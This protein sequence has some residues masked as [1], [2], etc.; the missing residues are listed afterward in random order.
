MENIVK[1]KKKTP[2]TIIHSMSEERIKELSPLQQKLKYEFHNISFL[3]NALTHKSFANE[4]KDKKLYIEDNERLEFLG[5][6]I[7]GYI[8]TD[9]LMEKFPNYSEGMLSKLRAHVVSE[10]ILAPIASNNDLGNYILLGKGEEN[11]GGRL[12]KSILANCFE[13]LIAGIYLD[14][15]L[16][17]VRKFVIQN[18]KPFIEEANKKDFIP[19]FKTLVQEYSQGKLNCTPIYRV[20]GQNGLDHEKIFEVKLIINNK[21][22]GFGEGRSK[23]DAEQ[24]A[25]YEALKNLKFK[26][27]TL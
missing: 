1:K 4:S 8:I 2:A 10:N 19:D 24:K 27:L 23:K 9:F 13:A 6:A 22:F 3:N 26:G 17:A 5:D 14:R 11:S 18:V 21:T 15:G 20:T 25:A 7:L 16:E 12:K